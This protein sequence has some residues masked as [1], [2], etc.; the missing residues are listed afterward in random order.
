MKLGVNFSLQKCKMRHEKAL[1]EQAP[2]IADRWQQW[3]SCMC[4]EM[5]IL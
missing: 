4:D 3:R 1:G 2:C 5:I